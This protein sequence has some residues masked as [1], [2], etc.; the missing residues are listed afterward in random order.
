MDNKNNNSG[1][2]KVSKKKR[3]VLSGV[4]SIQATFNNTIV[5]V[6]DAVGNVISWSSAGKMGFRG[7]KKSTPYAAQI[8]TND[9]VEKAKEY[10]LQVA[11]VK[12]IGGGVGRESALRVLLGS[13]IVVTSVEDRTY[14]PHNGCR[15]P[16]RR[17]V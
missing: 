5:S 3:N 8:T 15:P 16:K 13:N 17:R 4:I 9:A 10:G 7:S 6:S 14:L 11:S 1:V 12:V 2:K